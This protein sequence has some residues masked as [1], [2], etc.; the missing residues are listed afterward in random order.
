[1]AADPEKRDG[2]ATPQAPLGTGKDPEKSTSSDEHDRP[3]SV[4]EEKIDGKSRHSVQ[5]DEDEDED[6]EED[7]E[8]EHHH[9]PEPE[10][11][12]GLNIGF[13]PDREASA[14]RTRSHSRAPSA[15]SRPLS[16]VPRRKRRGLFAQFAMIPEV[17]RPYDYSRKTKWTITMVV[18]LAA[19]GGPIGSNIFY[20]TDPAL[21]PGSLPAY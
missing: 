21:L 10:G 4:D 13:P 14:T 11:P 8:E 20:R 6:E 5:E 19:A 9:D 15:R 18:A 16:I 7:D 17:D 1:M 3:A 12:E 2:D